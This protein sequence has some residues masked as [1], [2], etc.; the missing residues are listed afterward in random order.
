MKPFQLLLQEFDACL[1]KYNPEAYK[2]LPGP[3]PSLVLNT[4]LEQMEIDD[5]NYR[6][7]YAWKNGF[8]HTFLD[9]VCDIFH[10][11]SLLELKYVS[12]VDT[13]F[14]EKTFIPLISSMDGDFLLFN[15][16]KGN[17]Y[18]KLHL[19]SVGLLYIESPIS[20]FDSIYSM[21]QTTIIAYEQGILTY[22]PKT[23]S[24]KENTPEFF[25]LARKYNKESEFWK[26]LEE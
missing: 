19:Y 8:D 6:L 22:N 20:Y 24:L 9:P 4:Y 25:K 1:Q 2:I 11:G 15:N 7:L 23:R 3:P 5:E 26:T 13:Y 17:D 12:K 10:W 14:W 18:G 16:K 21:I